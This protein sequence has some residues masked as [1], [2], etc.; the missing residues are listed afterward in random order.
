MRE[1]LEDL[2]RRFNE[3]VKADGNLRADLEGLDKWIRVVTD[4]Q[5]FHMRLS[6]FS[7]GELREGDLPAADVTISA[8]EETL[9]GLLNRSLSPFRALAKGK[10]KIKASLEDTLRLR[11]LLS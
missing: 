8:D 7:I 5:Q 3:R 1:D 10:L 9:K 4:K 6:E 2:I 11:K